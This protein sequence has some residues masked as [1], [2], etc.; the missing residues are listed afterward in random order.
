[1]ISEGDVSLKKWICL[2]EILCVVQEL[3]NHNVCSAL[4]GLTIFTRTIFPWV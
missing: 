4:Q 3:A 1:M 2:D